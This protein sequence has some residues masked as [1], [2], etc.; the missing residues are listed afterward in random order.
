MTLTQKEVV[1]RRATPQDGPEVLRLVNALADYEKLDRPTPE[2]QKRLLADTFSE[3]P[4]IDIYLGFLNGVA[5]GYAIVFETYSSFLALPSLYMEDLFVMP[6]CRGCGMGEALFTHCVAEAQRRGCGRMEW[7][8][9]DWN[10]LAQNYWKRFG[11]RQLKEWYGYRLV[12]EQFGAIL[13][14]RKQQG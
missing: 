1:V 4:R 3:R 11:A 13:E 10:E 7:V 12:A 2:A 14:K 8:T 5:M 6:E 9:L